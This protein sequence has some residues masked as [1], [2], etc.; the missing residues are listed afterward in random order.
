MKAWKKLATL[1]FAL[2]LCVPCAP[3]VAWGDK[4]GDNTDNTQQNGDT[5]DG[6]TDDGN[7]DTDSGNDDTDSG[8][9]GNGGNT[10]SGNGGN[11][12]T[13]N[14]AYVIYVKDANGNPIVGIQ[15][16]ICEYDKATGNK[17]NCKMPNATDANGKVTFGGSTFP[18]SVYIFNTDFLEDTS[19]KTKNEKDIFESY[20]VYTVI[21]EA[22]TPANPDG[23]NTDGDNT[24]GGNTDNEGD[25]KENQ[26]ASPTLTMDGNV[27]RWTAVENA[28]KY[29]YKR[30]ANGKEKETDGLYVTLL[31]G[32]TLFVKALSNG[33][34]YE[35]SEWAEITYTYTDPYI[36]PPAWDKRPTFSTFTSGNGGEYNRYEG[37]EGYYTLELKAGETKYYSFSVS[38]A[39]QYALVTEK[40]K[41]GL[42]IERCDASAQY[43]APTTHPAQE[44]D[45]GIL[46]SY[47]H[48]SDWHFNAEWRATYK[49][50]STTNGTINVRFVRVGDALPQPER[51]TTNI[52]AKE[53][54][55]KAQD[56]S[57]SFVATEV[58]WLA[59][60]NPTYFYDENYEMTFTDLVTG[61]EKTAKGFYRMGTKDNPG[62][63]IYV[64][65]NTAPSR[66]LGKALSSI[67]Y[68]GDNLTLHIDT[69]V[70]G[71][72]I[73]DSYIDFIMNNGGLVDNENGGLPIVGDETMSCYMNA[74]NANGMFPV[75]QELFDFLNAYVS[76]NPPLLD[77]GVTVNAQDYWL[78]PCYYYLEQELGSEKNPIE[79]SVG[80]NTVVLEAMTP[81]YY[82]LSLSD[83]T[84][85]TFEGN[86]GLIAFIEG[87]NYGVNANGFSVTI[88]ATVD[89][90]SGELIVEC[91]S[92]TAGEY[93][94]TITETPIIDTD[95]EDNGD[96]EDN[97][98]T[99]GGEA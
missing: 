72:Y 78:A 51:I 37:S 17:A 28:T 76:L 22:K 31:D 92:L 33:K 36:A 2:S 65:I 66:Y 10:D 41:T 13:S 6:T 39:G 74:A 60:D 50:S 57:Q 11:G 56:F 68:D 62:E 81:K 15:V 25:T 70:D 73:F 42:T 53:I 44:L 85:Y 86:T 75:N 19:Y 98:N 30:E 63:V 96:T 84:S 5:N 45:K 91:K 7:D 23:G 32:Q 3:M 67:Q 40:K 54:V 16:G 64:A 94:L 24:D 34:D 83:S 71:N 26:L 18:E 79:L 12:E 38:Q 35:D 14:D 82:K 93:T 8:N 69:D 4:D 20:G 21:L 47:V 61:E 88:T 52:K 95:D 58:P 89:T 9:G 77:E 87:I 55:G 90:I 48:C 99:E 43:I 27:A 59:T 97:G 80:E 1:L 49:I 46:Y 29:L